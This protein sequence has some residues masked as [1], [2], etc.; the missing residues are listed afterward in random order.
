MTTKIATKRDYASI[1]IRSA[2]DVFNRE[3]SVPLK[4]RSL[5]IKHS[6]KPSYPLSIVIGFVGT[7]VKGQVVYSMTEEVGV[8]FVKKMFPNMLP[9]KQREMLDDILGEV[10]NMISGKASIM[11]AGNDSM[12]DITPPIVITGESNFHFLQVPTIV[13][14]LDSSLGSLEINI[15]FRE[16]SD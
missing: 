11:I 2:V 10:A 1:F 14:I 12:I 6:S 15:A 5:N 8:M 4:K 7:S 3:L 13:L 16:L 9:V